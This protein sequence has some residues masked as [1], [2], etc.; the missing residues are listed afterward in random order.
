MKERKNNQIPNENVVNRC[1]HCSIS[2]M[3]SLSLLLHSAQVYVEFLL[4]KA[5]S[6][7]FE[8]ILILLY[9]HSTVNANN[10]ANGFDLFTF[11]SNHFAHKQQ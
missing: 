5:G 4:E 2:T 9:I 6:I 10:Y 7:F 1:C 3:N 11:C 8:E